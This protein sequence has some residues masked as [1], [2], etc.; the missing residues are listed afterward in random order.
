MS[1]DG[2]KPAEH[3]RE[4]CPDKHQPH[5]DARLPLQAVREEY[6]DARRLA[7]RAPRIRR[8]DVMTAIRAQI[9]MPN[10]F[11]E[12]QPA[13]NGTDHIRREDCQNIFRHHSS[14]LRARTTRRSGVPSNPK[15]S[16]RRFSMKRR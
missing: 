7:E 8:T 10:E 11:A 1:H 6:S 13:R 9:R 4:R 14:S 3:R 12:N 16:R 5:I 2:G 15:L